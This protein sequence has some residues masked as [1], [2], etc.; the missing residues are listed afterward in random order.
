MAKFFASNTALVD[1][2]FSSA[3]NQSGLEILDST[4][5]SSEVPIKWLNAGRTRTEA[6]HCAEHHFIR[7]ILSFHLIN[8]R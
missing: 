8:K 2:V 6:A 4:S 5:L 7:C 1:L 3:N